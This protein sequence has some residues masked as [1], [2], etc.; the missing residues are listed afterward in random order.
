VLAQG[1]LDQLGLGRREFQSL[2]LALPATTPPG[3]HEATLA[4]QQ[5]G[6]DVGTVPVTLD[7]LPWGKADVKVQ[8]QQTPTGASYVLRVQYE[9]NAASRRMLTLAGLPP[10]ATARLDAPELVLV[11]GEE[12][13]VHVDVDAPASL[14][15]GLHK[16]LALL[17][18]PE[19]SGEAAPPSTI[20]S[21]DR[22]AARVSLTAKRLAT[23]SPGSGDVAT[24]VVTV[25][26]DGDADGKDVPVELFVDGLLVDRVSLPA[27]PPAASAEVRLSWKATPGHHAVAI[28]VD[29]RGDHAGDGPA[30]T[31]AL[32][33]STPLVPGFAQV[34]ETPGAWPLL[35]VLAALLAARRRGVRPRA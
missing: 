29:S 32:D 9:G 13:V 27:L 3:R 12:R 17:V 8:T 14:P 23:P 28:A 18:D 15:H 30:L 6:V 21:L 7:V 16:F 25:R 31:D 24:W 4:L 11:P 5:D 2:D 10:G 34:K 33:V 22:S 19:A 26:N 20:L 35:V 1:L